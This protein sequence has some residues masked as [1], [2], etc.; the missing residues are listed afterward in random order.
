[1]WRWMVLALVFINVGYFSWG[2]GRLL[3]YGL[4]PTLQREPQRL[5]QQ[6]QSQSITLVSDH[7]ATKLLAPAVPDAPIVLTEPVCLQSAWLDATKAAT[8]RQTLDQTLP[9]GGWILTPDNLSERWIIYLGRYANASDMTKKRAQLARMEVK[10]EVL[11]NGLSPGLSLGAYPSQFLANAALEAF[12]QRGVRTAHVVMVRTLEP[13][14]RL[15]LKISA[16]ITLTQL[17]PIKAILPG[18]MLMPCLQP[19]SE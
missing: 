14:Y 16:E 9:K 3:P 11:K 2:Q 15:Y 6:I 17:N 18:Q 4:G 19:V 7:E 12:I 10:S 5:Q 8:V 13:G 1:M